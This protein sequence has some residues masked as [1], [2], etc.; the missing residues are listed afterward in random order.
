[1]NAPRASPWRTCS[2]HPGRL[3]CRGNRRAANRLPRRWQARQLPR[4]LQ[5]STSTLAFTRSLPRIDGAPIRLLAL[6]VADSAVRLRQRLQQKK[7]DPAAMGRLVAST[8]LGPWDAPVRPGC[9]AAVAVNSQ[10]TARGPCIVD[11]GMC[12]T[13]DPG[14]ASGDPADRELGGLDH[15][16]Q[17]GTYCRHVCRKVGSIGFGVRRHDAGGHGPT[18]VLAPCFIT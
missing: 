18:P 6:V 8:S 12:E 4:L 11:H 15:R 1:M 10:E 13:P 14:K 9:R 16:R 5:L 17:P 7:A 3:G 2:S